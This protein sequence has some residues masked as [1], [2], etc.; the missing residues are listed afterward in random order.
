MTATTSRTMISALAEDLRTAWAPDALGHADVDELVN[1]Q[2]PVGSLGVVDTVVFPKPDGS[3]MLGPVLSAQAHGALHRSV[4]DIRDRIDSLLEPGVCGYRRGAETGFSYSTENVRFQEI[5]QAEAQN[6][7]YVVFADIE[8]F[9]AHCTWETVLD[10]VRQSVGDDVELDRLREFAEAA[11][12]SG[13][14]RLPAGY[15]D[16]RLL[17]NVVLAGVDATIDA[18]FV[19]WVD[20][21]RIF[22]ESQTH[23]S[24]ILADLRD[25]AGKAGLS[26]NQSKVS[27]VEGSVVAKGQGTPLESVY[28]PDVESPGQVRSAL[29]AVFFQAIQDP[30]QNRRSIRFV[31]PRLAAEEDD[32]AMGWVLANLRS[33]PWEAPR[34]CAYLEPFADRSEVA[35]AVEASLLDS[36]ATRSHWMSVRLAALACRT[37]VSSAGRI[38]IASHAGQTHSPALWAL[39]LRLLSLS[40]DGRAVHELLTHGCLDPRAGLSAIRDLGESAPGLEAVVPE[41]TR[42]VLRHG[43]APLPI[44]ASIL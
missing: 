42:K 20:D 14:H 27:I 18:P 35:R 34:F 37:G 38:R 13:L 17:G 10:R 31:L 23:A 3:S 41:A 16:A 29:R 19:R 2:P 21:Y 24:E 6:A 39:L 7:D 36:L 44:V 5:T 25:E 40:G 15:A 8:Q 43:C 4:E 22:A 9:F 26:L 11:K 32:V 28:H 1:T 33:V 30:V 12:A